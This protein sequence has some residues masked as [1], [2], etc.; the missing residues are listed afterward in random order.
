MIP[1]PP[2]HRS[3]VRGDFLHQPKSSLEQRN[4]KNMKVANREEE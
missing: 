2:P 4:G 1:M 3:T